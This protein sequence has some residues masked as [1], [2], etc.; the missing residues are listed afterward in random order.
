MKILF[1]DYDTP[2]NHAQKEADCAA[3]ANP[4]RR[5]WDILIEQLINSVIVAGIAGLTAYDAGVCWKAFLL[6]LLIEMRKF[7]KL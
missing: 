6:T 2:Q 7:R 5:W 4:G 1:A 3:E